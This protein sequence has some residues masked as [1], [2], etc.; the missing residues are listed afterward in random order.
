M[1]TCSSFRLKGQ[2]VRIS[3]LFRL[4]YQEKRPLRPPLCWQG[5][6]PPLDWEQGLPP[7]HIAGLKSHTWQDTWGNVRRDVA[8]GHDLQASLDQPMTQMWTPRGNFFLLW[9]LLKEMSPQ[10]LAIPVDFG[11]PLLPEF[12]V[13][14]CSCLVTSWYWQEV[15]STRGCG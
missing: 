14:L 15:D 3:H 5:N 10:V 9:P 11:H 8:V 1:F 7:T 13:R 4:N 12:V 2:K 6:P